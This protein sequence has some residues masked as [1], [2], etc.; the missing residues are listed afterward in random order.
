MKGKLQAFSPLK[1]PQLSS[2]FWLQIGVA[3]GGKLKMVQKQKT[4]K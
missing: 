3:F 2:V 4:P 1:S